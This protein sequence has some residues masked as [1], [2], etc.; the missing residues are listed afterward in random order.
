VRRAARVV[1]RRDEAGATLLDF[2]ARR[3]TY[4]PAS[5]W[6]RLIRESCVVL[7]GRP[8]PETVLLQVDD[9]LEY[10]VPEH[11]EPPVCTRYSIL[12]ED[13]EL[14]G[15][16]K[17]AHLP[18][19][20]AGRFFNHT[21][22]AL[23]RE[24]RGEQ[25][26]EFVNRLDRE[27]SGIVLLAKTVAAARDCRRQFSSRQ[28]AKRYLALVEGRFPEHAEA[29]GLLSPDDHSRV[30][31]KLRFQPATPG[32]P[33][34]DDSSEW[35][36][37]RFHRLDLASDISLVEVL[38]LTGRRHQIRAVLLALGYPVVGDKLYGLDEGL[39]LRFAHDHLAEDDRRRLRLSRQALHASDLIL[40]HPRTGEP[41]QLH[42][43][44]P[45]D[46]ADLLA[47]QRSLAGAAGSPLPGSAASAP[48]GPA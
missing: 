11:P 43:P 4:Q 14:L 3:F 1:I 13:D 15:I 31:H 16:D 35:T 37:T 5:T 20:P 36:V 24:C 45:A 18:C 48:S 39:F 40:T 9:R 26:F 30:I 38:P 25:R 41:L 8:V 21:L 23:L 29:M 42:A 19:H 7:N 6:A 17:P 28:V 12:F 44:L 10:M 27:T 22:W 2:L 46:M 47:R 33:Q 34:P 32:E